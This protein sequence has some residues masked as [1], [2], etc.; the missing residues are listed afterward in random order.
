MAHLTQSTDRS[1]RVRL[2]QHVIRVLDEVSAP[3]LNERS[4]F[5]GS[6]IQGMVNRGTNIVRCCR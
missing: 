4:D 1:A 2:P 5:F 6:A 3:E